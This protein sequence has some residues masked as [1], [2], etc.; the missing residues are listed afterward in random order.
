M[1]SVNRSREKFPA[2]LVVCVRPVSAGSDQF[3]YDTMCDILR[4]R[5][6][7]A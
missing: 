4:R 3:I 7:L 5:R 2:N 1:R 6:T